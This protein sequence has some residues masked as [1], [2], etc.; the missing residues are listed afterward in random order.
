MNRSIIVVIGQILALIPSPF[1]PGFENNLTV[2]TAQ[3]QIM[4]RVASYTP[5]ESANIPSQW[6][7]LER[8]LYR[9]MPPPTAFPWCMAISVLVTG[10]AANVTETA[11]APK[12]EEKAA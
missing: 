1:P 6:A 12:K 9:Y 11:V 8:N 5:P 2:L 10:V 7:E 4:A 3:L